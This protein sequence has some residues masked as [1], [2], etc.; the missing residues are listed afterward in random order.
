[1]I[2]IC[3]VL[4]TLSIFSYFIVDYLYLFFGQMSI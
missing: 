3:I 4:M 2:L 1:M